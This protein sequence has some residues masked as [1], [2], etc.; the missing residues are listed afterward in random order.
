MAAE[1]EIRWGIVGPG[2]I[3]AKVVED[4]P[5]RARRPGRRRGLPVDRTG[6]AS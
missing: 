4:F 2:R 6:E 3:A 1:R 5:S